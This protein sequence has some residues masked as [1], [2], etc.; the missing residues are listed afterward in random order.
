[1]YVCVCVLSLINH[2]KELVIEE[3]MNAV[4]NNDTVLQ[5]QSD[6][7]LNNFQRARLHNTPKH[8]CEL[9]SISEMACLCTLSFLSQT[10]S[11]VSS[12]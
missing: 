6:S 12:P 2:L 11:L 1:M 8:T 5:N 9:P 3:T 7:R 4:C 10:Y